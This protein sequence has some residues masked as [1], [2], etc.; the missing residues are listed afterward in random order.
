MNSKEIKFIYFDVGGVAILDYSKTNKWEEM[1]HDLNIGKEIRSSFDDL[2]DAHEKQICVGEPINTF[3]QEA[4]TKLGIHFP[5]EYDM[6]LDFVNRFE[7]NVPM[8]SLIEK[9]RKDFKLGLLTAQYP[10]MLNTIFDKGLL[11]KGIWDVIIDSSVEGVTKPDPKIYEIA[12]EKSGVRP[13][14]ILF[15]DNKAKLL[16]YPK[17]KGW[18]VFEYDPADPLA[19][20]RLLEQ[21]IYSTEQ[22]DILEVVKKFVDDSFG[23]KSDHF[24]RALYWMKQLKPDA[25]LALQISA[26]S[27][28]IQR[29]FASEESLKKVENSDNG[30]KDESMLKEHQEGGGEIMYKFLLKNGQTEELAEK[31]KYLISKHEVGGDDEQ[32]LLKD[33]DSVSYFECN[34]DH[35]VTKYAPVLGK[36]KVKSKFDWMFERITSDKA[37]KLAEPMYKEVL[38]KLLN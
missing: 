16:E 38:N 19:S 29:A 24:E 6:T 8:L 30:F 20:T 31:V 9:L 7:I 23:K 17:S 25:D 1:L 4:K 26:Y 32:N 21:F 2:F 37:K 14:L 33:A 5:D 22:D 28:D 12:E 36:E 11:P 27:H 3:V 15:V 35:F 34:A 13:E 10:N 18:H